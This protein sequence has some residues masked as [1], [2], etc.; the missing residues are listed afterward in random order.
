VGQPKINA[1]FSENKKL[2]YKL[3]AILPLPEVKIEIGRVCKGIVV[4]KDET[5]KQLLLHI[6]SVF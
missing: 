5:Q 1:Q 4:G 3:D 2:K 6:S